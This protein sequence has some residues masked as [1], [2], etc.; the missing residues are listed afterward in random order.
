MGFA[1][2]YPSYELTQMTIYTD[3]NIIDDFE[4]QH[5]FEDTLARARTFM[6]AY[7]DLM[8]K[9][10]YSEGTYTS[11]N[12]KNERALIWGYLKERSALTDYKADRI[13]GSKTRRD[14]LR[15]RLR[16]SGLREGF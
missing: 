4:Q 13:R 9:P 2:L 8:S 6:L 16:F 3:L 11:I 14:G 7:L 10:L 5:G 1:A 12:L 15:A